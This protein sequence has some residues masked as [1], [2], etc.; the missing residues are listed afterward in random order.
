VAVQS[1]L[2]EGLRNTQNSGSGPIPD[3]AVL[4]N[5]R[6]FVQSQIVIPVLNYFAFKVAGA[7]KVVGVVKL[8]QGLAGF[9]AFNLA[10]FIEVFKLHRLRSHTYQFSAFW[11]G[12]FTREIKITVIGPSPAPSHRL[13]MIG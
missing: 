2:E 8:K 5:N 4:Q 6:P 10:L 13:P 3:V 9:Y 11:R 1:L 7:V 12:T